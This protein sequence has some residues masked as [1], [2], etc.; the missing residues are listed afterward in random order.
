MTAIAELRDAVIG[1]RDMLASRP[2]GADRFTATLPGLGNALIF[3]LLAILLTLAV[4]SMVWG[5][6]GLQEA[7]V[8]IAVNALPLLGIALAIGFTLAAA[9][10]R[11]TFNKLAVPIVYGLTFVLVL[12]LPLTLVA[13]GGLL[14]NLVLVI[15]GYLFYRVARDAG[16]M[17]AGIS[18]AFAALSIVALVALPGG[19]YM[20]LVPAV[21][22]A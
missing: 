10:P 7:Y 12:Q 5:L 20:L 6:P 4:Q 13:V 16:K 22:P 19:L 1:W 8:T 17:S 21:P 9:R 2:E 3:Y 15:L 14:A 11:A 18:I